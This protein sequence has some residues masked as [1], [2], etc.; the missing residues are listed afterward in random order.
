MTFCGS[1]FFPV[2]PEIFRAVPVE[3]R[4]FFPVEPEN[5]RAVPGV[6]GRLVRFYMVPVEPESPSMLVT[7]YI[8]DLI[9]LSYYTIPIPK[10]PIPKSIFKE[11]SDKYFYFF[12]HICTSKLEKMLSNQTPHIYNNIEQQVL[13]YLEY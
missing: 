13:N 6:S 10:S 1:G 3:K 4:R 9:L 8:S 11:K 12:L 2:Q 7:E 5:M